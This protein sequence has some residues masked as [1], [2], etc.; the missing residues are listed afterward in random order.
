MHVTSQVMISVWVSIR[1]QEG[2]G[3]AHLVEADCWCCQSWLGVHR[4]DDVKNLLDPGWTDLCSNA[5]KLR[6]SVT[7]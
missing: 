2:Q 7:M 4:R 5:A 1:W 3:D 6:Y